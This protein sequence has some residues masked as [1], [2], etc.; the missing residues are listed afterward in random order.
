[1]AL[2]EMIEL[3]NEMRDRIVQRVPEHGEGRIKMGAQLVVHQGQAAVFYRDG[4][5]LDAFA[6]QTAD[7]VVLGYASI[8][9]NINYQGNN[10]SLDNLAIVLDDTSITGKIEYDLSSDTGGLSPKP[11]VAAMLN[12]DE[13]NLDRY[14]PRE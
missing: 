9:S 6:P 5:S 7:P 12:V 2:S 11:R 8:S 4:K 10:I 14:L 3:T 13:I 1:M